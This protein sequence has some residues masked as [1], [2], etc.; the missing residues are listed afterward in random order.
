MSVTN[1]QPLSCLHPE[2]QLY[3]HTSSVALWMAVKNFVVDWNIST[4]NSLD[5]LLLHS[6]YPEDESYR[7]WCPPVICSSA[8]IRTTL[9]LMQGN[10]SKSTWRGTTFLSWHS[11]CPEDESLCLTKPSHL[12]GYYKVLLWLWHNLSSDLV[13]EMHNSCSIWC[14]CH[15]CF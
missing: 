13:P 4:S 2:K 3:S 12:L 10:V 15:K 14:I 1:R 5:G 8:A 6:W 7:L 11:S 9:W